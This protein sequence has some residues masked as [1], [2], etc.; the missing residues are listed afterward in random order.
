MLSSCQRI[1]FQEKVP[2][3]RDLYLNEEEG[4]RMDE[5]REDHWRY[6]YEDG[7]NNKRIHTL[8]WEVYIKHNEDLIKR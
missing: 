6:I 5:T 2:E 3:E 4:I 7:E 1:F 8:R